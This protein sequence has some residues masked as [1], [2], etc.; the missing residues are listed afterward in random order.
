MNDKKE[1]IKYYYQNNVL[2][3]IDPTLFKTKYDCF[4]CYYR[5]FLL[6]NLTENCIFDN[7]LFKKEKWFSCH[8]LPFYNPR[9]ILL[10]LYNIV[11]NDPKVFLLIYKSQD[12]RFHLLI[13]LFEF[14]TKKNKNKLIGNVN[15]II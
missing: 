11:N 13:D 1:Q 4:A 12:L 5:Q 15:Y 10:R 6:G 2:T 14:I 7:H 9:G 8:L 3:K